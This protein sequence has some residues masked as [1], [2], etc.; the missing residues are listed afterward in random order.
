MSISIQVLFADDIRAEV[1]NKISLMGVYPGGGLFLGDQPLPAAFPVFCI[2]IQASG[3]ADSSSITITATGPSGKVLA[4]IPPQ[5]LL[6][7]GNGNAS[8]FAK[9][10]P[11]VFDEY[12]NYNF[13][14]KI[15]DEEFDSLLLVGTQPS[16]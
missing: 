1:G 9:I 14:I 16:A 11:M 10:S 5:P 2:Y 13:H 8:F 6:I 7:S 12:G 4:D 3:L 15:G